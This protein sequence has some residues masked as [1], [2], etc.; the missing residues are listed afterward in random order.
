M[1]TVL[2]LPA[3]AGVAALA[4]AAAAAANALDAPMMDG[5]ALQVGMDALATTL[6]TGDRA[7][8][9]LGELLGLEEAVVWGR[10]G[11][12]SLDAYAVLLDKLIFRPD[13]YEP[14]MGVYGYRYDEEATRAPAQHGLHAAE[15]LASQVKLYGGEGRATLL[16]TC[17]Q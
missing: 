13:L 15:A 14:P 10:D 2:Q 17:D 16:R 4:A 12:L 7:D 3:R 9:R 5:E 6:R 8:L 11:S 1:T